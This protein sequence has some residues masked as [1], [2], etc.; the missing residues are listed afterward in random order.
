MLTTAGA[1]TLG[2]DVPGELLPLD[3]DDELLQ[4]AKTTAAVAMTA[5]V[6][7]RDT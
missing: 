1:T 4:A 6:R 5:T 2:A 7:I 3:D